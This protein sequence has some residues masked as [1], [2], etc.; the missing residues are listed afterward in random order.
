MY[1]LTVQDNAQLEVTSR[2]HRFI[3]SVDG[4]QANPLDSAYAAL[5]GCAGVYAK[6]ACEQMGISAEGIQILCRAV[7]RGAHPLIPSK[8]IFKIAFPKRFTDGERVKVKNSIQQCPVKMLIANGYQ[9]E[10]AIEEDA[11]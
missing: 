3:Y 5:T 9:T 10:F 6:K 1:E 2:K 7:G 4:S 8:V 11:S